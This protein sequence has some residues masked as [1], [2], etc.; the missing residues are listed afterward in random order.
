MV[1]YGAPRIVRFGDEHTGGYTLVQLIQTSSIM[2]HFVDNVNDVYLDVFSCSDFDPA[3]A[4]AIFRHFFKPVRVQ[5][6]FFLR[7]A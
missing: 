1:P 2:A 7:Q 6:H 4:A 5:T 3:V